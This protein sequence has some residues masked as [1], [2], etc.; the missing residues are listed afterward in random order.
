MVNTLVLGHCGVPDPYLTFQHVVENLALGRCWSALWSCAH[1]LRSLPTQRYHQANGAARLPHVTSLPHRLRDQCVSAIFFLAFILQSCSDFVCSVVL[2]A[3]EKLDAIPRKVRS[4]SSFGWLGRYDANVFGGALV[5][6]GMAL[7][8]ACPGTVVVQVA[9]GINSGLYVALG[10]VLGGIFFS[11]FAYTLKKPGKCCS[12]PEAQTIASKLNFD[13]TKT[14]LA[15]EAICAV[16]V[17]VATAIAPKGSSAWVHP[18]AGGLLIGAAQAVSVILTSSTL[19]VSTA[20]EQIGQYF[21][22]AFGQKDVATPPSP[23]FALVFVLGLLAGSAATARSIPPV[24]VDSLEISTFRAVI[25]GFLMVFGARSAG[26]CTS[27]HGI[28]GLSAFS[29][30]SLVTV[31]AM[32]GGGIATAM[33]MRYFAV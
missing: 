1:S 12:A 19:G 28:S 9:N 8:G 24:A 22:Q 6:F 4:S 33:S 3:L 20:Y 13:S 23:P 7:T 11:K 14:F 32:F 31:A 10:C 30:S 18:I 21:W 17:A 25:G 27:G 15:F 5:G 26:G 16:I 29:F 2:V